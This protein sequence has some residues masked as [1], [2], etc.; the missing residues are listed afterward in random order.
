MRPLI[1]PNFQ[2]VISDETNN[3]AKYLIKPLE[4]GMGRTIGNAL[5]RTL[6]STTPGAAVFG[7][8]LEGASHEY[9]TYPGIVETLVEVTL[10]LKN[11][12]LKVDSKI[13]EDDTPFII[14]LKK[15]RNR[16]IK[17]KDLHYPTGVTPVDPEYIL[18]HQA[19][20]ADLE[21]EIYAKQSRGFFSFDENK[22]E[23]I[24]PDLIITD[25]NYSGI[26]K[27]AYKVRPVQVGDS[28][29]YE[30][31]V[32]EVQTT[33]AITPNDAIG[34]SSKI[35]SA[36]LSFFED[37]NESCL[38]ESL[39]AEEE[40][41]MNE[42]LNRLIYDLELTQRS[43]NCLIKAGINTLNDLIQYTEQDIQGIRNLGKT[44]LREIKNKLY[45]LN[46]DFKKE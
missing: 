26:Q 41:E 24:Y 20:E 37:L 4:R 15:P 34:I 3:Y 14:E 25:S 19:P 44:S 11:L 40:E 30:E 18:F 17:A 35:I 7:Y 6:L 16:T 10:S 27:V 28:H 29:D 21:M 39:I 38:K 2:L 31:L 45:Q 36:H 13:I 42:D 43:E 1:K 22:K 23:R 8:R 32:I 5:R 33:G 46:V 9:T 12:I